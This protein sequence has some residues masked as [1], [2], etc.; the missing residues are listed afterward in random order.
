[1]EKVRLAELMEKLTEVQRVISKMKM[2][3]FNNTEIFMMLEIP[4]SS[5]Y[6]EINRIKDKLGKMIA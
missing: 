3:G 6:K 1:M 4:S 2:D 5:Y